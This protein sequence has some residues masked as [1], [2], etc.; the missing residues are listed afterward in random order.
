MRKISLFVL[1]S[2]LSVCL[3]A[4]AKLLNYNVV[5]YGDI[6]RVRLELSQ[7][8]SVSIKKN[9]AAQRIEISLFNTQ[10]ADGKV[11]NYNYPVVKS[12]NVQNNGNQINVSINTTKAF[13]EVRDS[14]ISGNRHILIFD[15][16]NSSN[17]TTLNELL[18][19]ANYYRAIGNNTA[20]QQYLTKAQEI[21]PKASV[22]A[23]KQ[24][25][26]KPVAKAPASKP[27]PAKK[28][29]QTK[30]AAKPAPKPTPKAE[31]APAKVEPKT[32][33][34]VVPEVEQKEETEPAAETPKK[35][36]EPAKENTIISMKYAMRYPLTRPDLSPKKPAAVVEPKEE[37]K[38]ETPIPAAKTETVETMSEVEEIQPAIVE[39][40]VPVIKA[41]LPNTTGIHDKLWLELFQSIESDSVMQEYLLGDVAAK[42]G[43]NNEA[44]EYL[45]NIPV[46]SEFKKP[47]NETLYE[48]YR[49]MGNDIDATLL[50]AQMSADS[51][52]IERGDIMQT[53]VKL[54]L[55]LVL[56]LGLLV[57]GI[58]ITFLILQAKKNKADTSISD[59]ELAVHKKNL[60]KAY[61]N[62]REAKEDKDE[63]EDFDFSEKVVQSSSETDYDNPPYVA[64]ELTAKEE[65][66]LKE[67]EEDFI[68]IVKKDKTDEYAPVESDDDAFADNE[69]KKKMILKLY[70]DGW[71]IEE[72]A[73]EL[74]LSQREIEFIIK[75][76]D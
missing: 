39:E 54:W 38:A 14:E 16:F 70:N 45:K 11:K 6:A 67:E 26:P 35:D 33:P 12:I 76:A 20:S 25:A 65:I 10:N 36:E 4:Q 28:A 55:A 73:K 9:S 8:A 56:A 52:K 32:E 59:K 42:V 72:I 50:Y 19:Y 5:N 68:N 37:P 66:E 75:M 57:V 64:E 2:F 74:Q 22:T 24:P 7:K 61:D 43:A 63:A 48:V 3:F 47:A 34:K 29:Q 21:D 60:K 41:V 44:I 62:K 71:A 53:P 40:P 27:A 17:P 18:S 15:V 13:A 23:S 58:V 30:P 69:Y 49:R 46:C 1:L 51:L 31:P